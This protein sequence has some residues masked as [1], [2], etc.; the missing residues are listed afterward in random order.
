MGVGWK[1]GCQPLTISS[2]S[3]CQRFADVDANE[4]AAQVKCQSKRAILEKN[5]PISPISGNFE[6]KNT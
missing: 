6:S 1:A 4:G 2:R 3:G 5:G